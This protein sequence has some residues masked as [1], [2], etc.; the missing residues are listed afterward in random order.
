MIIKLLYSKYFK[1]YGKVIEGIS[2]R[3]LNTK[4]FIVY[5]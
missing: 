2:S 4:R 3:A 1:V 5:W